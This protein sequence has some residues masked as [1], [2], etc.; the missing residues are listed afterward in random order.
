MPSALRAAFER[1]KI[2]GRL[3]ASTSDDL[4]SVLESAIRSLA[5]IY[6]IIDGLDECG[7]PGEAAKCF[8]DIA[9]R[10]PAIRL[11]ILSR[12]VP[13]I[14]NVL[15]Q[16]PTIALGTNVVQPDIDK[17]LMEALK[18]LPTKQSEVYLEA[19]ET[20]S[21]RADG[22]FLFAFLSVETL[23][24]AVDSRCVMEAVAQIPSGLDGIYTRILKKIECQ[25]PQRRRLAGQ[26]LKW[27]CYSTR[28]LQWMELQ[29]ALSWD[30]QTKDF[31]NTR[32]PFKTSVLELC[33]PLIEYRPLS[34]SF[35]VAHF[36][37]SEFLCNHTGSTEQKCAEKALFPTSKPN[38]HLEI[39]EALLSSIAAS[40][41]SRIIKVDPFKFPLV[42][43][44]TENWCHHLSSTPFDSG[45][46][47]QLA[48]FT[49][50]S[51][52]RYIWIIRYLV[53]D[54]NSFPLQ[55]LAKL[56]KSVHDWKNGSPSGE[57]FVAD[58]LADLQQALIKLDELPPSIAG[59]ERLS[60]FERLMTVRDLARAYTMS[61]KLDQGIEIF[62]SALT[63]MRELG[64]EES[65]G[66]PW[67][68]NSL[69]IL[70][71]QNHQTELATAS[72]LQ[73]L[74][75]Q[76]KSLPSDHLDL[77]LT[78]NELGRMKRHQGLYKEAEAYH[79]R[80]LHILEQI[81][82]ETDLQIIWTINTLARSYRREGRSSEAIMLHRKAIIGQTAILGEDHPHVLWTSGDIA[83]CLRD[84]NDIDGAIE[85]LQDVHVRRSNTI[86]PLHPD[87]LWTLND[88][89]LLYE[90]LEDV[91]K[92]EELHSKALRGQR[93]VLGVE[94]AHTKW[95]I[96]RLAALG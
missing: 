63:R 19:I 61:R 59:G 83:R 23:K 95:T 47:Q 65:L 18:I 8:E 96:D 4:F 43:Y 24:T 64:G 32:R 58:D 39:A 62:S 6:I 14:E 81:L 21:C 76:E 92:A 52:R 74:A 53:F 11:C 7:D 5:S 51:V 17:Y 45:L 54:K 79:L 15:G 41:V 49:S 71:D 77:T 28:P 88:L 25:P 56:Q 80:A 57:A 3:H 60:N 50:S 46:A 91:D 27:V 38:A 1:A 69:G 66:T 26:I 94:H 73:A 75:I 90:A 82:P 55:R 30:Q 33:A 48:V 36:S 78:I 40:P 84:Q 72:Q 70:Y 12:K 9:V 68:L 44:A 31:S 93:E 42:Q 67:L 34:D 2:Y 20:I 87:T 13:A 29:Y 22:M 85:I 86:G 10:L 89:G 37:V 35:H 16:V